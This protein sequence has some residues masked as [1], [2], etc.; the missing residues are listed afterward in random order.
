MCIPPAV[1]AP[2]LTPNHTS[3]QHRP[4]RIHIRHSARHRR[5]GGQMGG[6]HPLRFHH[7]RNHPRQGTPSTLHD[8]L[9]HSTQFVFTSDLPSWRHQK[10][11]FLEWDAPSEFRFFTAKDVRSSRTSSIDLPHLHANDTPTPH[12]STVDARRPD[13]SGR[14]R[15]PGA[16]QRGAQ[17]VRRV[18]VQAPGLPRGAAHRPRGP[19]PSRQDPHP[20]RRHLAQAAR[21]DAGQQPSAARAAPVPRHPGGRDHRVVA[22]QPAPLYHPPPIDTTFAGRNEPR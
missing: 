12:H 11:P 5:R 14:T 16:D 18:S 19:A 2:C 20:P 8:T 6:R 7:P 13:L 9:S 15:L 17:G 1:H 3:T 22:R 10:A 21:P 4:H